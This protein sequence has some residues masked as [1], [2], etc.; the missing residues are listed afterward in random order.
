MATVFE[1][2]FQS[3]NKIEY[4][5]TIDDKDLIAELPSGY[6]FSFKTEDDLFTLSYEG[7]QERYNPIIS[8]KVS[9]GIYIND[10]IKENFM[11]DLID[12]EEGRFKLKIEKKIAGV[13]ELFWVGTIITDQVS[14]EDISYP[15]IFRITAIDQLGA[16]STIDYTDDGATYTG[17]ETLLGHIFNVV[18]KT[19]LAYFH[20]A[21][22]QFFSTLIN[23]YDDNH[24]Y[25]GVDRYDPLAITRIDHLAF[26]EEDEEGNVKHFSCQYVLK[27]IATA[28]GARLYQTGGMIFMEQ[29]NERESLF[30]Y[31]FFYKK[32]GT[33]ESKSL[34]SSTINI[35]GQPH[36][37]QLAGGVFSFLPGLKHVSLEYQHESGRN[38]L[39]GTTWTVDGGQNVVVGS[40][41]S[42]QVTTTLSFDATLYLKTKFLGATTTSI[43]RFEFYLTVKHG[44]KYLKREITDNGFGGFT[45]G[46]ME[47]SDTLAYYEISSVYMFEPLLLNIPINFQTPVLPLQEGILEVN[48]EYAGLYRKPD[49]NGSGGVLW[50]F[51]PSP[52]IFYDDWAMIS[53]KIE[54]FEDGKAANLENTRVYQINNDTYPNNTQTLEFETSIG[55]AITHVTRTKLE[56]FNGTDWD[57]STAWS[58]N[59]NG[60]SLSIMELMIKEVIAGQK[61]GT[62]MYNGSFILFYGF[63]QTRLSYFGRNYLMMSGSLK[64]GQDTWSGTWF[65]INIV[66]TGLTF[67]AEI[68]S[69]TSNTAGTTTG[70]T[71]S[72]TGGTVLSYEPAEPEFFINFSG[73]TITGIAAML[74]ISVNAN[75]YMK[76]FR[77]GRLLQHGGSYDFTIDE[78]NNEIDLTLPAIGEN[79]RLEVY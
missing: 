39:G 24:Q 63:F 27:Q 8:S 50:T 67:G 78:A 68:S 37:T 41:I 48:F 35:D 20:G 58:I 62:Y 44:T 51:P 74:P 61:R 18:N 36:Q 42:D 11:L 46:L 6:D 7:A 29:L 22:E 2:I 16:L 73:A 75:Q 49:Q 21:N 43:W 38:L 57:D 14:F 76:L 72:A 9:M 52:D 71:V 79:F 31:Y 65:G 3:E 69:G 19:N 34:Y 53:P 32:D 64:A 17:T 40:I 77:D 66:R 60:S 28:F 54:L 33:F 23:W 10:S 45:T 59:Q 47:W 55:D 26:Y 25:D 70:G 5:I 1:D 15:F 56:I 30:G 4:R 12:S 13:F